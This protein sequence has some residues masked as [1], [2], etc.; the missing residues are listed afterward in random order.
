MIS[1]VPVDRRPSRLPPS[2]GG[3][4]SH[5][6]LH[7]SVAQQQARRH[8]EAA[9]AAL[10]HVS[11][12]VSQ[13]LA[14]LRATVRE[15]RTDPP[16]SLQDVETLAETARAA[17][18]DVLTRIETVDESEVSAAAYR[19]VQEA[20]TNALRHS[21]GGR[22]ITID[23]WHANDN[24]KVCVL[25]DGIAVSS[26]EEHAGLTGLRER[27]AALGGRLDAGPAA[28]GWHVSAT[29]PLSVTDRLTAADSLV[30][31]QSLPAAGQATPTRSS[32]VPGSRPATGASPVTAT[33]SRTPALSGCV[34][35]SARPRTA[36]PCS[37]P[38]SRAR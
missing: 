19:L 24:L 30:G 23:V 16:P 22:G 2:R 34:L 28:R 9:A 18:F 35:R 36:S 33:C 13:A 3:S 20:L 21:S 17:G 31:P 14:E 8:P 5:L 27:V 10:D 15:L 29:L 26:G 6:R 32:A 1:S 12:A 4:P 11:D 7:T 25:D 37:L 38:Q